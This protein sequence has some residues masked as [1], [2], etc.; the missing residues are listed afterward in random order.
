MKTVYIETTVV[1]YLVARPSP[2]L[3]L[4]AHQ[5]VTRD[6]WESGRTHYQ[7]VASEEVVREASLGDADMAQLR[8]A[9]LATITILPVNSAA[10]QL[11]TDI[12]RAGLLPSA[13]IADALH[14]AI[15]S[16]NRVDIL[17]TW[18]CRHLAN[19]NLVG[20]LRAF[21]AGRGFTLPEICTLIELAAS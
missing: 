13:A 11:A 20:T 2:D 17:V 8:L 21:V 1:S 9:A 5:Q 10:R 12:I 4:A 19:P 15:A 16:L 7:C 14:A 3:V 18:N 6:W